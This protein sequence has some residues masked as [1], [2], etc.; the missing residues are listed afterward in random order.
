MLITI[1]Y[2]II[3]IMDVNWPN[4]LSTFCIST[5]V[6]ASAL[7]FFGKSL[8]NRWID[9]G[10]LKYQTKLNEE[11]ESYRTELM[12]TTNEL[13]ERLRIEYSSLYNERLTAKGNL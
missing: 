10:K 6:T 4:L 3:T 8:I 7:G 2:Q 11:F 13:Q 5:G 12:R 1:F 9:R